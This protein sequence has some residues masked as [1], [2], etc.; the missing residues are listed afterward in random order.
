[1]G[2]NKRIEVA[3]DIV[4]LVFAGGYCAVAST[5]PP[6]GRMVP[7]TIGLIALA[8]A[9]L[10][11]GGNVCSAIR[12]LTHGSA[13]DEPRIVRSEVIAAGWAVA[14]LAGLFLIGAV[15]ATAVFFFTYFGAHGRRWLLAIGSAVAMALV[16]WGV[17]GQIIGL[18]LPSGI[19]TSALLQR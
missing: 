13:N 15:A 2:I 5:Y 8:L 17:F 1:M 18:D 4:W 10:Q 11:F 16:T 14:L 3:I 19:I 6:G 12:P 9:F 7:L